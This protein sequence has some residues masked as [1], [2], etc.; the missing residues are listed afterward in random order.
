[1]T[2]R[3]L[4]GTSGYAYKPWKGPFYPQDLHQNQMLEY[5]SSRL[6]AV[7]INNTFYRLPKPEV[8]QNWSDSVP[9]DFRFIIKASRRITHIRK[10]NEGATEP[11]EYLLDTVQTLGDKLGAVLFQLPPNMKLNLERLESFLDRLPREGRHAFEF[12]NRSWFCDD[13]FEALRKAGAAL[14]IADTGDPET[15][16]PWVETADWGYLRLRRETYDTNQIEGFARRVDG[17]GWSTSYA[18]FKHE[19]AGAGPRLAGRYLQALGERPATA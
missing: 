2:C 13:V 7:E 16:A 10:L 12:R 17:S 15:D 4:A 6:P 14:C 5:Y 8:L 18:F 9:E 11:L 19:D 1:M 3:H